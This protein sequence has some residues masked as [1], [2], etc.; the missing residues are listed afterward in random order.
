ME[1]YSGSIWV[2][3]SLSWGQNH[4]GRRSFCPHTPTPWLL[5]CWGE[6]S[7]NGKALSFEVS[8]P[9]VCLVPSASFVEIMLLCRETHSGVFLINFLPHPP[10][11]FP[12]GRGKFLILFCREASPPAPRVRNEYLAHSHE[13]L[14]ELLLH[15]VVQLQ[16]LQTTAKFAEF[17][18][19]SSC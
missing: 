14:R 5:S 3:L 19:T 4:R 11:P 16:T 15:H 2:K 12:K 1:F 13:S 9:W 17:H 7:S 18:S 6:D 8:L 10:A